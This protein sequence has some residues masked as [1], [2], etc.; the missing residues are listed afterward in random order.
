VDRGRSRADPPAAATNERAE[1]LVLGAMLSRNR[2]VAEDVLKALDASAFSSKARRL[3]FEAIAEFV[4]KKPSGLPEPY[5]VG[6]VLKRQG[7]LQTADTPNG[8]V[9]PHTLQRY[10][11]ECSVPENAAQYV[12]EVKTAAAIR[13][14]WTRTIET[15]D[16]LHDPNLDLD[17]LE[18]ELAAAAL[19]RAQSNEADVTD[20]VE[21]TAFADMTPRV[22]VWADEHRIPNG[23]LTLITGMPGEGKSLYLC[24]R[25]ARWTKG[26]LPGAFFE[27]PVGV[28]YA[29]TEDSLESVVW[30]RLKA[31]GADLSLV[32]RAEIK[33]SQTER[34]SIVLPQ[35]VAR[36]E[37]VMRAKNARILCLDPLLGYI[38][39][40]VNVWHEPEVKQALVPLVRMARRLDAAVPT[41]MHLNKSALDQVL[42]RIAH[43]AGFVQAARSVLVL[44]EHPDRTE[45]GR[46]LIQAKN[47]LGPKAPTLA[48]TIHGR[49]LE[50]DGQTFKTA[51]LEWM[52]EVP[53]VTADALQTKRGPHPAA[54]LEAMTFLLKTLRDGPR[55]VADVLLAASEAEIP[56]RT[57]YTA[58]K[59][60]RVTSRQ[61][62]E[63]RWIWSLPVHN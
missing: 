16:R 18:A 33:L 28:V 26:T 36:L 3:V 1:E 54:T 13:A 52:G 49:L 25:T 27:T 20:V 30:P 34:R 56:T 44:S 53:H 59:R 35:D 12:A 63:G 58:R 45:H 31:A 4:Y 38:A 50:H 11:Q 51:V 10:V 62:E 37:D 17:A 15:L 40:S 60:L 24:D 21:L 2:D 43:S 57:L 32:Y 5:V 19:S 8:A 47:N 61:D 7:A 46:V 55:H 9:D 22:T 42:F 29:S 39:A 48:L 6:Q 14:R 41:V 23:E